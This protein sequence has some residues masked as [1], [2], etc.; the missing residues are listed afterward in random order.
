V[1]EVSRTQTSVSCIP[2]DRLGGTCPAGPAYTPTPVRRGRFLA[3]DARQPPVPLAG[4]PRCHAIH[5]RASENGRR[6]SLQ[7]SHGETTNP[8]CLV[9]LVCR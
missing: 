8:Q 6:V 3:P 1:A 9:R 2:S 5:A 7:R 4:P